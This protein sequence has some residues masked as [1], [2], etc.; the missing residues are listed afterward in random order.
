M[1]KIYAE[2]QISKVE[3]VPFLL[4]IPMNEIQKHIRS[5]LAYVVE[6]ATEH[7]E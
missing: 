3:K 6:I 7:F 1:D 5:A 4:M 2:Q